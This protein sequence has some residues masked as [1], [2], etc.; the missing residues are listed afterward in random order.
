MIACFSFVSTAR[1]TPLTIAVPSSSATCRFLISSS[2]TVFV[3]RFASAG[4]GGARPGKRVP[5][6]AS[7][8][9]RTES[10]RAQPDRRTGSAPAQFPPS[11]C[12]GPVMPFG[13]GIWELLIL[14]LVLLLVFGPKRLPEMGRQLGKGMREF[15][16]S[17]TGDSRTTTMFPRPSFRRPSPSS[18]PRPR[19]ASGTPSP[20]L[21][22]VAMIRRL[23]PR[24]LGTDEEATVVEHLTE[25]RHRH[26]H[27]ARRRS[28][29]RSSSRSRSTR[30]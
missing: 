20:K 11:R 14:L 2:A 26:L 9:S 5:G 3:P 10:G 6:A 29:R 22:D 30:T 27:R 4:A 28:S 16:D 15:K 25:L 19:R 21:S 8:G 24:R 12:Y 1:S 23:L 18:P 13:I 7:H 17:V